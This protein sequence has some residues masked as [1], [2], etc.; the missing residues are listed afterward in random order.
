M[1]I[2]PSW[3]GFILTFILSNQMFAEQISATREPQSQAVIRTEGSFHHLSLS[4]NRKQLAFT[5]ADGQSLRIL[6]L[7]S[8]EVIEITPHKTGPGF[9]WSPDGIRLFYRELIREG[10]QIF[11]EL[12]AYDTLLNKRV[13]FDSLKGSSGSP[14]LNPFDHTLLMI[15]E[16]GILQKRLEFPGERFAKWQKQ[17]KTILGNWLASQ[18]GVLWL[19]EL[20]LEL[21]KIADDSSGLSSFAISPDGRRVAWATQAGRV[22][23]ALDGGDATLI[24]EGKDPSWHPYRTIL[25]YTAARKIGSKVYDYDLRFSNLSGQSRA[26]THTQDLSERWPVW[27]DA[28]T[29]LY[30]GEKTTD[31]FKLNFQDLAPIAHQSPIRDKQ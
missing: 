25:V 26:L 6:D 30:T 31:L 13:A 16:K 21:K 19:G 1:D 15:H 18:A 8:Q 17:R 3:I 28:N 4:P 20:G 14:I 22:Y 10:T 29:L 7:V 27:L 5:N 11:S 9:F 12:S 23:A 2:R 24:G